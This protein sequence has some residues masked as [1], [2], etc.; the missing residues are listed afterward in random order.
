MYIEG[1]STVTA[2]TSAAALLHLSDLK[3]TNRI[4]WKPRENAMKKGMRKHDRR[5]AETDPGTDPDPDSDSD[6]DLDVTRISDRS[7][8]EDRARDSCRDQPD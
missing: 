3:R 1:G 5:L 8:L 2:T 7:Q 4:T 6:P